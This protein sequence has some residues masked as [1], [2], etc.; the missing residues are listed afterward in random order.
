MPLLTINH[1][2]EAASISTKKKVA[3]AFGILVRIPAMMEIKSLGYLTYIRKSW[4]YEV[5]GGGWM[6]SY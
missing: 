5:S 1:N 6:Y 3:K 2:K 4:C